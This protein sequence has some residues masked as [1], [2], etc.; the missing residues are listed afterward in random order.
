MVWT[1]IVQLQSI[2]HSTL[3]GC[4]RNVSE[5]EKEIRPSSDPLSLSRSHHA[6]CSQIH[7]CKSTSVH[8]AGTFRLFS[9]IRVFHDESWATN[10]RMKGESY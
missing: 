4:R 2:D 3:L 10:I 6:S 7:R 8:G 1:L 5:A 9:K